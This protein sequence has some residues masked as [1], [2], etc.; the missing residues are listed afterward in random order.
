MIFIQTLKKKLF[1]IGGDLS[2]LYTIDL[3][4]AIHQHESAIGYMQVA[5]A[6]GCFNHKNKRLL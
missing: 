6:I 4:S 3:V 5:T 2:I 1:L